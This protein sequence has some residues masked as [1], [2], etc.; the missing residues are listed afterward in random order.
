MFDAI[1]SR[2]DLGLDLDWNIGRIVSETCS[3]IEL[4]EHKLP[5]QAVEEGNKKFSYTLESDR[6]T[7]QMERN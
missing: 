3:E 5:K 7:T 1:A 6:I 4:H 2:A